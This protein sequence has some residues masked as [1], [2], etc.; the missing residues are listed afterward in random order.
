MNAR[1]FGFAGGEIGPWRVVRIE[2]IV[3]GPLTDVP[4][5]DALAGPNP[6]LPEG[7]KWMLR[8]VTRRASGPSH[9]S[10]W[11][12]VVWALQRFLRRYAVAQAE[13]VLPFV[14]GGRILDL[15][16]GEGYVAAALRRRSPAWICSVD[17]GPFRLAGGPYVVYGGDRLP[18]R[19]GLFDTTLILLAL[20]HCAD[21]DAVLREAVRVT[22]GRLVVME[23][24]SRNPWERGWLH[25]LDGWLNLYRHDGEMRVP[26]AFRSPARWR[27]SFES[28][29]L[30]LTRERWLGS[31]WE[32]LVHHPLL[33][34]LEK[35]GAEMNTLSEGMQIESDIIPPS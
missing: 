15:G 3:G 35:D 1:L 6:A 17:V 18:F 2:A 24:V 23:S 13:A 20:H 11:R 4:R 25:L 5:L 26:L 34:V 21:P 32:R 33:F 12:P 10:G 7:T 8:G 29:G 14:V 19:D 9:R 27:A 31:R 22:R 28:R 30:R 16:A